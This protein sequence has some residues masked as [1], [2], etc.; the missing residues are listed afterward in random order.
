M[1]ILNNTNVVFM[2]LNKEK[3]FFIEIS[4]RLYS[5]YINNPKVFNTLWLLKHATIHLFKVK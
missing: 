3:I 1:I 4:K 5:M 2:I